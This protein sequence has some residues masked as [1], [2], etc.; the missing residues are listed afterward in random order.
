M[1]RRSTYHGEAPPGL[2]G[3]A[4]G[5]E[6]RGAAGCR[7]AAGRRGGGRVRRGERGRGR[8]GRGTGEGAAPGITPPPAPGGQK[9]KSHVRLQMF[10]LPRE[11]LLPAVMPA[12]IPHSNAA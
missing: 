2:A 5:G 8:R 9:Q 4:P 11:W 12:V 6:L 7:G 3:G 1:H 10:P